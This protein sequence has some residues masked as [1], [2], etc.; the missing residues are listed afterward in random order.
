MGGRIETMGTGDS[1]RGVLGQRRDTPDNE[2]WSGQWESKIPPGSRDSFDINELWA[3]E[4]AA[5]DFC[6]KI[7]AT[8]A[9]AGQS[10]PN[11]TP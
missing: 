2:K 4:S 3:R 1:I 10:Q 11:K 8:P 9:I 5:C 7:D 6:V